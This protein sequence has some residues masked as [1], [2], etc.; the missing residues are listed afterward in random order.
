L[1]KYKNLVGPTCLVAASGTICL[2]VEVRFED[3]MV[4][5]FDVAGF[6]GDKWGLGQVNG[7]GIVCKHDGWF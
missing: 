3:V 4:L 5:E 1:R 7:G 2:G 6:G